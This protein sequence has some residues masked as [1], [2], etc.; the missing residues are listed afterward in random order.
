M[1][2]GTKGPTRGERRRRNFY[3]RYHNPS[4]PNSNISVH[5]INTYYLFF[6][7]V[8]AKAYSGYTPHTPT[9]A[10]TWKNP[11][12]L[13]KAYSGHTPEHPPLLLPGKP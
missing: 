12:A 4:A 3:R 10:L 7:I 6:I 5:A 2:K 11:T 9:P 13:A 8:P 1:G